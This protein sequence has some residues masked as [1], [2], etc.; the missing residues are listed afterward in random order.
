MIK[1]G[2]NDHYLRSID[3]WLFSL[4]PFKL[5]K[6]YEKVSAVHGALQDAYADL[7][8][9]T[10]SFRWSKKVID[11]VVVGFSKRI[12]YPNVLFA[13]KH[14]GPLMLKND[15]CSLLRDYVTAEVRN[16]KFLEIEAGKEERSLAA[17]YKQEMQE[18]EEL[19]SQR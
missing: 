3:F 8:T 18:F 14:T 2:S 17:L 1:F 16:R 9:L 19:A 4:W 10:I 11:K 5:T 7:V 6:T 12:S 13:Q 15:V